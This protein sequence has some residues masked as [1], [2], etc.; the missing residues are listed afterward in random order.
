MFRTP[1]VVHDH[2]TDLSA[3]LIEH[4][5]SEA[6]RSV[7]L[8]ETHIGPENR[9]SQKEIHFPTIDFQGLC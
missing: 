2:P 6:M 5:A 3:F 9:P 8:P 7:T 4:K 1:G